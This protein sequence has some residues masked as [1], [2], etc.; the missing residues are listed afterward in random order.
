[1]T[2]AAAYPPLGAESN[3]KPPPMQKPMIP[4]GPLQ[5]SRPARNAR[6]ASMSW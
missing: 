2:D 3:A 1:L 5:S 4:I 6:A